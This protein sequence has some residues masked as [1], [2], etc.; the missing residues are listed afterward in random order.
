MCAEVVLSEDKFP[1]GWMAALRN[2]KKKKKK[3]DEYIIVS[4]FNTA[5]KA[6]Y[7]VK[8]LYGY[9]ALIL[10]PIDLPQSDLDNTAGPFLWRR[11]TGI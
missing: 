11:K 1:S 5:Q 10:A 7:S 4:V 6:S 9:Y 2:G 3:G 8:N